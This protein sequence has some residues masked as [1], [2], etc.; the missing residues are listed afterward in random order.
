MRAAR[1]H[2]HPGAPAL[3][4]V[5]GQHHGTVIDEVADCLRHWRNLPEV[6]YVRSFGDDPGYIAALAASVR[7]HWQRNGQA[8]R[9]C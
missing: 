8:D 2:A 5:R 7:A 9:W 4:P 3:P 1:L 6:R